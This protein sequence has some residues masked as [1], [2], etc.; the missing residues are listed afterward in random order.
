MPDGLPNTRAEWLIAVAVHFAGI[1]IGDCS[2]DDTCDCPGKEY[3]DLLQK[4]IEAAQRLE[5]L[6]G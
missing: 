6:E 3:N 2:L 1:H 4:T 5:P